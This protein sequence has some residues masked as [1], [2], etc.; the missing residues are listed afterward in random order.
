[1]IKTIFSS[2]APPV[3]G[4]C[5]KNYINAVKKGLKGPGVGGGRHFLKSVL[6][7]S[8]LDKLL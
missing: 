4:L 3:S 8:T 7:V 6:K 5:F 2:T 1:M